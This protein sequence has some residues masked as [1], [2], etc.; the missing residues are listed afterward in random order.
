MLDDQ[1]RRDYRV[2]HEVIDGLR[3]DMR[4]DNERLEARIMTA[5][6]G[7]VTTHGQVHESDRMLNER[8]HYR[9]EQFIRAAELAQAKRDGALGVL[10]FAVELVARNWRPITAVLVAVTAVL[11]AATADLRIEVVTR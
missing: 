3:D 8:A 7:F 9:F 10:R 4:E 5:V 2:L 6:N 1:D 11:F